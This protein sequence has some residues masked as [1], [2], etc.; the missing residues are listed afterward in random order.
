MKLK[1]R[2]EAFFTFIL[3]REIKAFTF[4]GNN[5]KPRAIGRITQIN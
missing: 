3:K 2:D 5:L 4:L 1:I